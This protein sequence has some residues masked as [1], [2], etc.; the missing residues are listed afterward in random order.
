LPLYNDAYVVER[1]IEETIKIE[2][3]K[4]LLQIQVLDDSTDDTAPFAE[5]LCERYKN[6]GIRSSTTIARIATDTKAG[7][8]QAAWRLRPANSSPCSTPIFVRRPSS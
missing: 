3:P 7:A 4:E 6:M 5:A 2:Y 1:L 8:L